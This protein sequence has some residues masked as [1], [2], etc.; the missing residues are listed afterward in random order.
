MRS[1]SLSSLSR[2][3]YLSLGDVYDATIAVAAN[4]TASLNVELAPPRVRSGDTIRG[5][6]YVAGGVSPVFSAPVF[7]NDALSRDGFE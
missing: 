4:G 7:G 6:W 5:R 2:S 3:F 1:Q